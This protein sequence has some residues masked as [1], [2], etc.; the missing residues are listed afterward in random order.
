[1]EKLPKNL[2]HPDVNITEAKENEEVAPISESTVNEPS[3]N[4]ASVKSQKMA[5]RLAA[6]RAKL[7]R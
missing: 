7:N 5:A 3:N 2:S 6:M 1:M 4:A